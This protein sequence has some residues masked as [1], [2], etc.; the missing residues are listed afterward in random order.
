MGR[1][2][3]N[4]YRTAALKRYPKALCQAIAGVAVKFITMVPYASCSNDSILP[5]AKLLRG[6][7]LTSDDC[8]DDGGDYAGDRN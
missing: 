4:I 5:V 2:E 8:V 6:V 7:Y 1:N 3:R